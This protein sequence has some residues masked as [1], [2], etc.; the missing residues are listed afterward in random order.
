MG[1]YPKAAR[2]ASIK[3][4]ACNSPVVTTVDDDYVCIECG[5]SPI[6]KRKRATPVEP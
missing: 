1:K 4:I 2:A 6:E 5:E 3:C